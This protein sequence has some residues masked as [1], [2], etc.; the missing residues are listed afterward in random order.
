MSTPL[1]P[2]REHGG[3]YF[4]Q[5]RSNEEELTRLHIQ[6]HI[7]DDS[8]CPKKRTVGDNRRA[9]RDTW[10]IAHISCH[11]LPGQSHLKRWALYKGVFTPSSASAAWL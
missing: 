1:D 10:E 2:R 3:T 4:V 6:D 8:F 5:D 11:D 9:T 7:G